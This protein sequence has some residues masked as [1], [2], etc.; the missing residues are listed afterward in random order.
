V[1]KHVEIERR[2]LVKKL[3]KAMKLG[4]GLDVKQGYLALSGVRDV[5]I[6]QLGR[7][8]YMTIKEGEG[9]V[10][11][12]HEIRLSRKQ[13]E[14]L[15]PLTKGVRLAKV[16][17]KRQVNG[18]KVEIDRFEGALA[19]LIIAEVEFESVKESRAF[20]VPKF[21]G[22]EVTDR[23]DYR[24][25]QLAIHG[26]PDLAHKGLRYGALPY[27]VKK[28]QIHLVLIT[29]RTGKRWIIPKGR[30]EK[31]LTGHDVALMEAVEEAGIVGSIEGDKTFICKQKDGQRIRVYPFKVSAVLKKWPEGLFRERVLLPADKAI[32]KLSDP[33]LRES[34]REIV[35][36]MKKGKT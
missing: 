18:H 3:P 23:S 8:Y 26:L 33:A 20:E 1:K 4:R 11:R 36:L 2:F 9:L 7:G 22:T 12:E 31:G 32:K 17:Y 29:N 15:W 27:L 21:F 30:P 25:V 19:P 34:V 28:R 16:R 13:F 14:E 10:R 6:R 35:T 5:R 24:N